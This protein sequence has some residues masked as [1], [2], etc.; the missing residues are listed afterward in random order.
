[1]APTHSV[2][3]TPLAVLTFA[4][5]GCVQVPAQIATTPDQPPPP[6][7]TEET[8]TV[9][10]PAG[11]ICLDT[12]LEPCVA[13]CMDPSCLGWCAGER[14]RETLAALDAC[15][16][17]PAESLVARWQRDCRQQCT[18]NVRSQ[19][20]DGGFCAEDW[21]QTHAKWPLLGASPPAPDPATSSSVTL[22]DADGDGELAAVF[23]MFATG[24][25][26]ELLE[27]TAAP[28]GDARLPPLRSLVSD[29][30]WSM[31]AAT[32][33]ISRGTT[34]TLEVIHEVELGDDG[35]VESV[36]PVEGDTA[37]A[38]CVADHL[39]RDF[40]LP[41][42]VA[43]DFPVLRLRSS[44]TDVSGVMDAFDTQGDSTALD[45]LTQPVGG[46]K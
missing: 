21:Q 35:L 31:A 4:W 41:R 25:S 34:D 6:G 7:P 23:A 16:R 32:T 10:P 29:A 18:T 12:E 24:Y 22:L 13:A 28:P 2:R 26:V 27:P 30:G 14:C 43:A 44:V 33:C 39:R 38:E 40:A 11:V 37:L 20:D 8:A 19:A 3:A 15:T 17:G 45:A 1:M 42:R 9:E 36:T 46:P 5:L